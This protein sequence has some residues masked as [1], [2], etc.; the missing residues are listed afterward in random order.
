[1]T[2]AEISTDALS[3]EAMTGQRKAR[4]AVVLR[5]DHV[6]HSDRIANA[7]HGWGMKGWRLLFQAYQ[8]TVQDLL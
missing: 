4:C 7:P 8:R 5:P 3:N 2:N 6:V 1:M